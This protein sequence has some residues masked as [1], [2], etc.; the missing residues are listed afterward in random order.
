MK[1]LVGFALPLLAVLALIA[2]AGPGGDHKAYG[3]TDTAKTLEE[4]KSAVERVVDRLTPDPGASLLGKAVFNVNWGKTSEIPGGW[5][6]N[7]ATGSRYALP[8]CWS[9]GVVIAYRA[10]DTN[11]WIPDDGVVLAEMSTYISA[12]PLHDILVERGA[13][14]CN[15]SWSVVSANSKAVDY[16]AD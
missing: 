6:W 15:T 13:N 16:L 4:G 10:S 3:Q 2:L 11:Q 14:T 12:A 1:V 7:D 9:S 8:W 5:S